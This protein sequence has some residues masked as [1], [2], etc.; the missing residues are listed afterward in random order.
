MTW[1]L[2]GIAMAAMI[3]MASLKGRRAKT[4]LGASVVL[5]VLLAACS[6]SGGK[7]GVPAGTPAGN[8]QVTVTGVSGTITRTATVSLQVK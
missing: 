5:A 4:A 2:C 1:L 7:S 8:S 3:S 6:G